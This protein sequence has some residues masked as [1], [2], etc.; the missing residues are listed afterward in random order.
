MHKTTVFQNLAIG[1]LFFFAF[2]IAGY[3]LVLPQLSFGGPI[4]QRLFAIPAIY[5]YMH[6][7]FGAIALMLSPIQLITIKGGKRHKVLGYLYVSSV[8]F[9][10]LGGFYMAQDAY[11]GLSSIVALNLLALLWLLFTGMGI[12]KAILG[13]QQSHKRWMIRSIALTCAA[14]TLRLISPILYEFY[15]LYNAQQIIYWSCWIIN[16]IVAEIYIYFSRR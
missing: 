15:S 9:S 11:G 4:H 14:I 2:G 16:L 3:S 12:Y 8:L 6:T 5:F 10:A 7:V 13:K 1:T